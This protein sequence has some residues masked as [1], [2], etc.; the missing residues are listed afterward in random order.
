[1]LTFTT[2]AKAVLQK[3]CFEIGVDYPSHPSQSFTAQ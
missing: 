1:M 3:L 2:A